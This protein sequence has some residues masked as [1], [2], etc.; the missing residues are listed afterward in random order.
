MLHTNLTH[1]LSEQDHSKILQE[2]E[3][4]MICCGRMGPMCIPVYEV[5]EELESEYKNVKFADMEFD[6]PDAKVIRNLPECR[7]F[8]GIPFVVYYKNGQVVKATSSIQSI[9]QV[10]TILDQNFGK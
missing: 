4:V 10:T 9:E 3:N 8:Q 2:N 5:M 1:V 7:S 6:T